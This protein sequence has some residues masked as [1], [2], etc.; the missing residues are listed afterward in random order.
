MQGKSCFNFQAIDERALR[1]LRAL[2]RKAFQRVHEAS[3]K[4]RATKRPARSRLLVADERFGA[5]VR[6]AAGS[7]TGCRF[8][9]ECV[10]RLVSSSRAQA[11]LMEAEAATP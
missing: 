9:R 8:A 7:V 10:F 1:D 5:H 3:S 4:K 2:T 11:A 6:A